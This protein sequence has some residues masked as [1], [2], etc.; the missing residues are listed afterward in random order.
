MPPLLP[1]F[2]IFRAEPNPL[3]VIEKNNIICAYRNGA[4][5]QGAVLAYKK[6]LTN[7]NFNAIISP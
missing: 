4:P 7:D 5:T 3:A 6:L 2:V 1:N